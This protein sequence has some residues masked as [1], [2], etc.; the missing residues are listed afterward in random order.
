[1]LI[2]I[3]AGLVVSPI[4]SLA[5]SWR[6]PSFIVSFFLLGLLTSLP[7][8]TIGAISVINDDSVIFAG[9]LL[10]GVMVILL[11]II[12]L[13]GLL[14]NGV[15]IPPQLGK[16]QLIITLIV[17]LS[18]AFL[19]ADQKLDKW[20]GYFMILLYLAM[21]V[22]FSFRQ[23]LFSKMKIALARKNKNWLGM[24]LRIALGVII[25]IA[26]SNQVVSSTQY[27]ADLLQISPFFVSLIVVALGTNLPEISI[28]F[29]SLLSNK[30]EVAFADYLGSASMNTLL[31]GIFTVASD[32][33][34]YLPNHFAQRFLFL[35]MGVA[36]FFVF[37][38]SKNHI[39]RLESA[40][41]LTLY[42]IFVFFEIVVLADPTG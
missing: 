13:L 1:V 10:G 24:V 33:T 5:K 37:S 30:K 25:L 35:A 27:F 42:L 8:I 2:W 32:K 34:I 38:R 12:P 22:F 19:T 36:L 40:A 39:S 28:I 9:S 17:I 41:L 26:A 11:G 7:E 15:N 21:S 16:K 29:R 20:E 31:F 23:S 18:P 6:L 3:G 4:A 14:G